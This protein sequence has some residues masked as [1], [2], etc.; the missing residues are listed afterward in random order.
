MAGNKKETDLEIADTDS[1]GLSKSESFSHSALVMLSL[2]KCA[3]LG[4]KELRTGWF[5]EKTD[6]QG[7]TIRTY[8][9]DTR[10]SFIESVKSLL[11]IV[12]CDIDT[13]AKTKIETLQQSITDKKKEY[14]KKLD[15]SWSEI[16]ED[17]RAI[18]N[19]QQQGHLPGLLDHP[20]YQMAF[21]NFEVD[22]CRD[23][24]AEVSKLTKRLDFYKGEL[25]EA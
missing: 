4:S 5:N 1:Y 17:S 12:A 10:K 21:I 13:T 19:L 6:R 14:I 24:V 3:E 20:A 2:K 15:S 25:I 18:H 22:V 11:M 7:N 9:D 23:I 8:I 16:A